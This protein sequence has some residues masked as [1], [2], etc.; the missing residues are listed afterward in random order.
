MN[1]VAVMPK[2]KRPRGIFTHW[3]VTQKGKEKI[4]KSKGGVEHINEAATTYGVDAMRLYY[5]HVGSPFVDIE[6][7]SEA[8]IKYKNRI[9]NI[10]KMISQISKFKDKKDENLDNWLKSTIQRTIQKTTDAFENFDLRIAT[11][12]IFFECQKNI[13]WYLKRGGSNTDLLKNIINTWIKLMTPVAPHLSEEIWS[14]NKSTFVSNERY[15]N[16]NKKDFSEKEEVGEYL[17]SGVSDDIAEI[18]KV[19]KIKPKKIC[20]YT[21]PAWKYSLFR[22]AI[23]ISSKG[24]L[25]TGLIMKEVMSDPKIKLIAKE[26]SQFVSKLNGEVMRLNEIDKKRYLVDINEQEYLNKSIEYLK[27]LFTCEINIFSADD[28]ELYDPSNK[29][30]FAIP[31]RPAIFIE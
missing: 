31:L 29:K 2:D 14:R 9:A 8:V 10:Y 23:E 20:I 19:T 3:W 18:L 27:S 30:R 16:F 21:S 11:N 6:W 22:K 26:V 15:P 25:N 28:K 13:Q 5:A 1:H 12:E 17:L 4:S 7:D 24:K